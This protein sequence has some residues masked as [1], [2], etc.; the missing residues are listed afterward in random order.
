MGTAADLHRIDVL[1][2]QPE[3]DLAWL[4][5]ITT[6]TRFDPGEHAFERGGAAD[7]MVLVF[8]GRYQIFT[9]EMGERMLYD[10][11]G[12]GAV[13]GVLPFSRMETYG[14]EGVAVE[15]TRV[16]HVARARRGE[17]VHRMPELAMRLVGRMTD[18][19]RESSRSEP[20][21]EKMAALGKLSAGLAHEL[22][23]PA[24]AIRRSAADLRE[25]MASM[26]PVGL[27]GLKLT[28]DGLD[29]ARGA[30]HGHTSPPKRSPTRASRP[31][32]SATSP[33]TS[34]RPRSP[35]CS[36]GPGRRSPPTVSSPRSR[37][38]PGASRA[39][40]PR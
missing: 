12:A 32:R 18:R 3:A 16:G 19:V 36:C 28:P 23:N 15:P 37:A 6:E 8:E 1:A 14:G 40:S 17:L 25:R 27:A 22:N 13:S 11:I 9:F 33:P 10:T 34:P 20:Q 39:S 5:S 2:D 24:T 21:R 31:R 30:S 35:A 4:A 26:P 7:R 29:A 38:R